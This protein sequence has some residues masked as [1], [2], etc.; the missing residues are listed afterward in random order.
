MNDFIPIA[1]PSFLGNEKKYIN[2]CIN[3]GWI[4]SA[5]KYIE[6]FEKLMAAY[7]GVKYGVAV[8]NGTMAL[9]LALLA[10]NIKQGDE[11]IVPDLTF[12]AT[13]NSVIYAGAEPV[14]ADVESN[15]WNIDI[16]RCHRLVS[17]RTKA[18]IPVHLYGQP[19]D[20]DKILDFSEKYNLSIVED[21]AEAHGA[22]FKGRKVGSFGDINCLSF[23]GN[24]IVTTGE[25]GICLTND[26]K[27]Y[28]KMRV[29]RDHGMDKKRRYW[30]T[31]VGYNYRMTNIQASI[32]CAQLEKIDQYIQSRSI[33]ENQY[34]LILNNHPIVI[35]QHN[36]SNRKK[37]CW[38]YSVLINSKLTKQSIKHIQKKLGEKGIDS[39]P[40]FAPLHKMPPYKDKKRNNL[41]NSPVIS[42]QG[43]SLPTFVDLEANQIEY[44]ANSIIDILNHS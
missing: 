18:I 41:I 40:F 14:L 21:C 11:V 19:C 20:M 35:T 4:S 30:H 32:G 7:C 37:V 29:L 39:R 43:I 44:I 8:A 36:F 17:K 1:K 23:Y 16:D 3:T 24:K 42:K 33:I 31:V 27:L 25:G 6:N 5:G 26:K 15:S 2:E 13:A 28:E 12:A 38:L 22:E 34:N 9:H 10:L